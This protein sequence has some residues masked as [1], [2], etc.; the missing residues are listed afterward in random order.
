MD[1]RLRFK[2]PKKEYNN[3]T[4]IIVVDFQDISVGLIIDAVAEVVSIKEQDIVS[5]YDLNIGLC[6]NY[7]KGI[8]KTGN[9]VKLLLDCD[10]LLSSD[11]VNILENI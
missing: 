5:P 10:K 8:G 6:N 2:K 1:V 7:I 9:K 11:E 3:R 4:C